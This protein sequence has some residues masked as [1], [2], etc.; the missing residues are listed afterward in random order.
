M[1][2]LVK[3]F[4]KKIAKMQKVKDAIRAANDNL[5]QKE[6]G[7]RATKIMEYGNDVSETVAVYLEAYANDGK[8]DDAELAK[9]NAQT[10]KMVD[11]YLS[12]ER[13]DLIVDKLFD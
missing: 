1:K 10:D 5:A 12:D 13:I 2:A 6:A 7:E 9:I 11:K 3:W 8:I 4:V